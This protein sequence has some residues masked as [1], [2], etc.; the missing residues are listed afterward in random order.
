M[1]TRKPNSMANDIF[2]AI[3]QD[4]TFAS[5]PDYNHPQASPARVV[6][7]VVMED[8]DAI[9]VYVPNDGIP[10]NRFHHELNQIR[11]ELKKAFPE[12]TVIVGAHD[13]KFTTIT[14]KQVF[15]GRLDGSLPEE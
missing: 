13:L 8:T 7:E 2:G 9:Y 6:T 12:R 5:E 3:N 4:Y 15:K 14:G 1:A 11:E 10:P